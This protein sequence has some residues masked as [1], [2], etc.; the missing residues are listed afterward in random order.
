MSTL[1]KNFVQVELDSNGKPVKHTPLVDLDP[2]R[3]ARQ[4]QINKNNRKYY[5]RGKKL[6]G[7]SPTLTPEAG[8]SSAPLKRSRRQQ[9][10]SPDSF[11]MPNIPPATGPISSD[12]NSDS[13]FNDDPADCVA[14]APASNPRFS[15]PQEAQPRTTACYG[16]RDIR[17]VSPFIQNDIDPIPDLPAADEDDPHRFSTFPGSHTPMHDAEALED[18]SASQSVVQHE[19]YSRP[20]TPTP[21]PPSP[22]SPSVAPSLGHPQPI[23]SA[24]APHRTLDGPYRPPRLRKYNKDGLA[25][26][27][28]R[29]E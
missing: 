15:S 10:L 28:I 14:V 29:L 23:A 18:L 17:T 8:P 5:R 27:T 16:P 4:D 6:R 2:K 24:S 1:F 11:G 26:I 13:I 21:S 19:Q 25:F 20:D 22:P 3:R 12:T 9:H 7:G